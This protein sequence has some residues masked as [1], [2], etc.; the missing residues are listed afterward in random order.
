MLLSFKAQ[1][2]RVQQ[3]RPPL[4]LQGRRHCWSW[5]AWKLPQL[6]HWLSWSV[7]S[8]MSTAR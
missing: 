8:E 3:T 2:I 7:S 1:T 6:S 4:Q 5:N